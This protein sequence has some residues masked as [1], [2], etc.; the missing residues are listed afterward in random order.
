M[1]VHNIDKVHKCGTTCISQPS[2]VHFRRMLKNEFQEIYGGKPG[3]YSPGPKSPH[4]HVGV[5]NAPFFTRFF[6]Y[7]TPRK[8]RRI[9]CQRKRGCQNLMLSLVRARSGVASPLPNPIDFI[10]NY[11]NDATLT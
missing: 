2:L 10:E 6:P 9:D 7:A 5:A 1:Y 4:F 8:S 11:R 3:R